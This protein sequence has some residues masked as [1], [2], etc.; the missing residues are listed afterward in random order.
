MLA[1][2]LIRSNKVK[3]GKSCQLY[4]AALLTVALL[5]SAFNVT[6]QDAENQMESATSGFRVAGL[7]GDE[8]FIDVVSIMPGSRIVDHA[9]LP[10][11]WSP[12][13]ANVIVKLG[14]AGSKAPVAMYYN[15]LL[16]IAMFVYWTY[17]DGNPRIRFARAVPGERINDSS[18]K[19]QR[20]PPW[21]LSESQTI[22]ALSEIHKDRLAAFDMLHPAHST[23]PG[24][25]G[26]T[27]ASAAGDMRVV[28]QR[29]V[30]YA[31]QRA[32][33]TSESHHWLQLTS[34]KIVSVLQQQNSQSIL[35][36]A[37][38]TDTTT[39]E[40]LAD[41]P[42]QYVESLEL[43]MVLGSDSE[44]VLIGSSVDDGELYVFVSCV[45]STESCNLRQFALL[46]LL[47]LQAR[48]ADN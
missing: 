29:L 12:T 16:D 39:A 24:R 31:S 10:V 37:I 34:E 38:E 17:Q 27:F 18:A 47:D 2:E 40:L 23:E 21:L 9:L 11:L 48:S 30:D 32:E 43:D 36:E 26:V 46:S 4:F 35:S 7:A 45:I 5:L 8:R 13:F 25:N 44:R 41:L 28:L 3:S 19:V 14:R 22:E 42:S 20:T 15:P 33:W 6:A 1:S